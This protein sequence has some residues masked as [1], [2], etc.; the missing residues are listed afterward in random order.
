MKARITYKLENG[1][2]MEFE[3]NFNNQNIIVIE[4]LHS[5]SFS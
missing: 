4:C 2:S 3:K 5:C 1:R